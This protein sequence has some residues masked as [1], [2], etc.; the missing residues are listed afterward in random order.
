VSEDYGP[1]E[2]RAKVGEVVG[3]AFPQRR[4]ELVV[5]PYEV[6]TVINE[7]GRTYTEVVARGAFD[8]IQRRT[9]KI[10]VYSDHKVSLESTLGK[11]VALYPN[12]P[13]GLVADV[14]I[15]KAREDVL[16][17]ADEGLL[18]ASAGFAVMAAR[19]G[20][21]RGEEWRGRTYRRLTRLWLGHIA[22][23]PEGAYA[24]HSQVLAV[25]SEA[26]PVTPVE[27]PMPN[28]ERWKLEE[29][30]RAAADID[31]RYSLG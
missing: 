1:I 29:Q 18:D 4:I 21:P 23:T 24:P 15:S 30:R 13:E 8:G 19:N 27:V 17:M 22:L 11:T 2:I 16:I 7:P 12:R 26:Q 3:V 6:E 5:M 9:R 20:Q 31:R 14:L 28:L 25:R 10:G